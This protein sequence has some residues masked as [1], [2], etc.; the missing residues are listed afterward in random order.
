MMKWSWKTYTFVEQYIYGEPK[1]I[2]ANLPVL[3]N[4]KLPDSEMLSKNQRAV[5]AVELC[6]LLAFH[7]F[8]LDFPDNFPLDMQ[9]P[10]IRKHWVESHVEVSFGTVHIDLCDFDIDNCPF[11]GYCNICEENDRQFEIDNRGAQE[12]QA[13]DFEEG[14][15]IP[16]PE[17]FEKFDELHEDDQSPFKMVFG[18]IYDDDG[19]EV[20]MSLIPVPGLCVICKKYQAD[21]DEEDLLCQLNRFDQQSDDHFKCDAYERL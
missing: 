4:E 9:Y 3:P 14:D 2:Y 11:P 19:N 16:K 12:D 18:G 13:V 6:N 21:D 8:H 7:H 17:D 10:I 5:L 20:D 15:L 1:P